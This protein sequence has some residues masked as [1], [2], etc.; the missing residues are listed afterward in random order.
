M[1]FFGSGTD[2]LY[3]Y[4]T[5]DIPV[6][7]FIDIEWILG[8]N[9]MAIIINGELRVLGNEYG[10]IKTIKEKPESCSSPIK[11][12]SARSATITVEKLCVSEI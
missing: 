9:I 2:K 6:G 5:K 1:V 3:P 11:I 12:T 7:E 4:N 8:E 10:Y